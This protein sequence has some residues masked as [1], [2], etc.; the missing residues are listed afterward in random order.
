MQ[1]ST[2][3]SLEALLEL[4][5]G[6]K[7]PVSGIGLGPLFKRHILKVLKAVEKKNE[8]EEYATILAFEVEPDKEAREL[9]EK[10]GIKVFTAKIVYHLVDS[11]KVYAEECL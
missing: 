1:S 5:K 11:F 8:K 9:A 2:L 3:G 4:L 10:S 7:I 6:A